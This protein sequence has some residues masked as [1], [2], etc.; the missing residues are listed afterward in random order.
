MLI[1]VKIFKLFIVMLAKKIL[2][3]FHVVVELEIC[4]QNN[5]EG[6]N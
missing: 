2:M 4:L 5:K 1:N 3:F 6:N